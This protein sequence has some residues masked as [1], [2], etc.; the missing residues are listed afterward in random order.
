M[1]SSIFFHAEEKKLRTIIKTKNLNKRP[2]PSE[3]T[4]S[5]WGSADSQFLPLLDVY[6]RPLLWP[7]KF[8]RRTRGESKNKMKE[9]LPPLTTAQP[10]LLVLLLSSSRSIVP[11]ARC[12]PESAWEA[13]TRR[14]G[15]RIRRS[16]PGTEEKA[17]MEDLPTALLLL[18]PRRLR[19]CP[20]C[21]PP[22][23]LPR[24]SLETSRPSSLLLRCLA[25]RRQHKKRGLATSGLSPRPR[26]ER[27][28]SLLAAAAAA[29]AFPKERRRRRT[30]AAAPPPPP[31]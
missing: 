19:C 9:V 22:P 26:R 14:E 6:R 21:S 20:F 8:S 30:A 18:L 17:T 10:R 27:S 5:P 15:S 23:L 24:G 4:P 3:T 7:R 31:A 1:K 25:T 2:R 13:R 12:C 28:S 29:A 11:C 16:G